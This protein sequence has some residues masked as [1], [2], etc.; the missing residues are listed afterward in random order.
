LSTTPSVSQSLAETI[1]AEIGARVPSSLVISPQDSMFEPSAPGDYLRCG[2]SALRVIS[3]C[4]SLAD[5]PRT[6]RILDF[7]CGHGRVMRWLRAQYPQAD[8]V[9]TDVNEES[10]KFC[11]ENFGSKPVV[12]G[13]DFTALPDYGEQDM[14]WAGSVFTHLPEGASRDLLQDFLRWLAPH[15]LAIFSTHGR[16]VATRML[17]QHSPYYMRGGKTTPVIS[18]YYGE[19]G[20]GYGAYPETPNYGISL[21]QPNWFWDTLKGNNEVRL[22]MY[23]ERAWDY[24]HDI[25]AIQKIAI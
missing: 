13:E 23:S 3:A 10:V 22:V 21:V 11:A 1:A 16:S 6:G 5:W 18:G 12:S 15:G 25:V 7:G 8:I 9:G 24:H 19:G 14:I 4:L 2:A 20:Y 17:E